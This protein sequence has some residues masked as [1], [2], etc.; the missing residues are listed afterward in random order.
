MF[1]KKKSKTHAKKIDKLVTGLI[2]GWAVAWMIGLSQ[3]KKGKETTNEIKGKSK[4]IFKKANSL[5]W[6]S[7]IKVLDIF[8]KNK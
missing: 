2:I 3:T 5:F 8:N 7:L 6:K 4:S 1:F